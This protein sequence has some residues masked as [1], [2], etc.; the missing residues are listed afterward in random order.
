VRR[1][2]VGSEFNGQRLGFSGHASAAKPKVGR[3]RRQATPKGGGWAGCARSAIAAA[4]RLSKSVP[5]PPAARPPAAA[6]RLQW[7]QPQRLEGNS[8]YL[9]GRSKAGMND[10]LPAF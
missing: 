8:A 10:C 3:R 6:P 1:A 9:R 4:G 2:G 7:P 5:S